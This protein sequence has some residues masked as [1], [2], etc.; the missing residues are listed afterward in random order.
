ME[1]GIPCSRCGSRA[2]WVSRTRFGVGKIVRV[3]RCGR[4]DRDGVLVPGTGC[5]AR[6][7]TIEAPVFAPSDISDTFPPDPGVPAFVT[8]ID[9]ITVT[10][11][12]AAHPR[13]AQSSGA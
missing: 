8:P 6:I 12:G 2:N 10:L 11:D 13:P 3:R 9:G 7:Q 4:R 1:K 5:G